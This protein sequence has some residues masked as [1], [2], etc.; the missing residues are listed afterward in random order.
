MALAL[1]LASP[2]LIA[3]F[4]T[5]LGLGL[6][7]RFAPQLNVFFLSMPI[8]SAVGLLVLISYMQFLLVFIRDGFIQRMDILNM[9]KQVVH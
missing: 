8:K 4:V 7:N 2:M 1:L 9:L 6:V 3:L 5:E